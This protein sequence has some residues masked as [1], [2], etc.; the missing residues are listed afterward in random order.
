[1]RPNL[2]LGALLPLAGCMSND[3]NMNSGSKNTMMTTSATTVTEG[4]FVTPLPA[5]PTMDGTNATLTA[6]AV[7]QSYGTGTLDALGYS[8]AGWL[9]P[10]LL[11]KQGDL[12][13]VQFKNT[14]SEAT[15]LHWHGLAVPADQ[16]GYP[17]STTASGSS[18]SYSFPVTARA[19][20]YWY[21]PHSNGSTARQ[22]YRGLAG[23]IR[24]SDA[25][26]EAL[27]LPS[28]RDEIP[29]VIQDKRLAGG[30]LNYAPTT[31]E[32]MTGYLGETM[33]VN[34]AAFPVATV[35]RGWVRLRLLNGSNARV[36]NLALENGQAMKL[37]GSDGGLLDQTVSVSKVLLGPAERVDVL[38]D[39]SGLAAGAS[40]YLRCETF[41]N[42]G[43]QGSQAFRILKLTADTAVGDLRTPPT[44]LSALSLPSQAAS[45]RTRTF[46]LNGMSGTMSTSMTSSTGM[47]SG[48]HTINGKTWNRSRIDETVTVGETEV[49]E[50][51][52]PS[53][54]IHPIHI[55]G[56]QFALL[57]RTG[58]RGALEAP[59]KGWKDTFLLLP[60]ETVRIVLT[61]PNHPGL[62]LLHC[63]N[64]EHEDDGMMLQFLIKPS[65]A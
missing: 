24:V 5:I 46:A 21:H 36:L 2:L 56:L 35:R 43:T 3:M 60:G 63:H 55:H 53:D 38:V 49:W 61:F 32:V 12:L 41:A 54:E 18:K 26:E 20:L 7:K 8:S 34:G 59:E 29:L 15:N 1:M 4:A 50:F 23:L 14:M 19:G 17:D 65:G 39:F 58:G 44:A 16:D 9:G 37:I 52:N 13:G 28:G 22:A 57:S 33:I 64:L 25:T 45:L 11:V 30:V 6:Q 48:M 62:F 40:T 31:A 47:G 27:G 51:S 42:G 10:T